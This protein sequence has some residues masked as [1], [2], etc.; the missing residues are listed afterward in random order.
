MSA[1][2]E[3]QYKILQLL[4]W[5]GRSLRENTFYYEIKDKELLTLRKTQGTKATWDT[6][7]L[8]ILKNGSNSKFMYIW[9]YISI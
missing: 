6:D 1:L 5:T 4:N 2:L 9:I 8:S 3:T 7:P